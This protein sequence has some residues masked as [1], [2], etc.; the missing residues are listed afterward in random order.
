ML[1]KELRV[2]YLDPQAVKRI[3]SILGKAHVEVF[4]Y[5]LL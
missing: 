4:F 5:F 3:D 2:L 1:E